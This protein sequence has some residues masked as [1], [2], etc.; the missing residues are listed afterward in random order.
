M[1]IMY[2]LYKLGTIGRISSANTAVRKGVLR[3][4]ALITLKAPATRVIEMKQAR[5]VLTVRTR[6]RMMTTRMKRP[7]FF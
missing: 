5:E 3:S 7:C 2:M 1:L 6:T 4:I